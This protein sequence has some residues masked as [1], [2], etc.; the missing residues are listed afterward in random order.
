MPD[1][2]ECKYRPCDVFGYCTNTLGGYFCACH[3]GYEGDG[4]T[5]RDVDECKIPEKAARCIENAECCNLPAHYTCKCKAGF[6]GDGFVECRG[7]TFF[8]NLCVKGICEMHAINFRR[9]RVPG[10]HRL[11]L[12]RPLRQHGR[13]PHLRMPAGIPGEPLQRR[14]S[15]HSNILKN[16][17]KCGNQFAVRGHRRVPDEPLRPGS[18]MHKPPGRLPVL[19]PGRIRGGPVRHHGMRQGDRRRNHT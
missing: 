4:A 8:C 13:K 3:E 5:C 19:L 1:A 9:R 11:R 2:N 14:K 15:I 17:L 7:E 18:Q 10:Q 12:Q 6:V 16:N